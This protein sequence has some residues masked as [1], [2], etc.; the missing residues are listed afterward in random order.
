MIKYLVDE[1]LPYYFSLWNKPEFI[2]VYDLNQV[3]TDE[4][5]WNYAK[6]KNLT[7]ITKDTDF[8]NRILFHDPPPRV[9]H[10]KTGNMKIKQ[11]HVFIQ[12]NWPE[13]SSTSVYH[14]LTNVYNDRIEGID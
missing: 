11:F 13:I 5:I 9:I 2:H 12:N 7:I 14:K 8:S 10:F 6:E 4:Y 3:K 1:N